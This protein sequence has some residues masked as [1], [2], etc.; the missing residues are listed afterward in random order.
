MSE[1][2]PTQAENAFDSFV[3]HQKKAVEEATKA[4][5][6]LIPPTFKEHGSAAIKEMIEGFRVLF[7]SMIDNIKE[8]LD[9]QEADKGDNQS[10]T[11]SNKVKVEVS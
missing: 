3:D 10:S 11:G 2:E 6:A 1:Q 9:K 5:E 8:E 7:N 4:F